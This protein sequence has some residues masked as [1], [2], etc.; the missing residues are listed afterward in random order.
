MIL[1]VGIIVLVFPDNKVYSETNDT[2]V[3]EIDI[4]ISPSGALFEIDN[5]KPGDWAPRSLFIQN[6]GQE[7]FEYQMTIENQG[8]EKLFNELVLELSD[9]TNLL[10]N[11][12]LAEFEQLSD[13]KLTSSSEEELDI[14]VRFPEHLGN[15]FQ[16]L[17][18]TFSLSFTAEGAETAAS[19]DHDEATVAGA[20]GS[21][22]GGG[23]ILPVTATNVYKF[24]LI[25][26]L[27]VGSGALVFILNKRK[28]IQKQQV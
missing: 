2:E 4:A 6:N 27:L 7:D 9:G 20:I 24:L 12:K 26:V 21:D 14:T 10:Y 11:G 3:E 15:E 1:V 13:R 18:T 25:G 5:M 28:Q 22:G 8:S 23:S 19:N 16:G 17:D